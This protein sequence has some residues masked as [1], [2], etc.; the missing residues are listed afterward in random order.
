[1]V[2]SIRARAR[3]WG[4]AAFADGIETQAQHDTLLAM[5]CRFGQGY[6]L[7]RPAPIAHWQDASR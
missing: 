2:V 5:G 6:L 1:M 3:A 7:D 4:R